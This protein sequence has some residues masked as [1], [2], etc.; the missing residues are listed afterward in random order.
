MNSLISISLFIVVLKLYARLN[1]S[2]IPPFFKCTRARGYCWNTTLRVC[3]YTRINCS[4]SWPFLF[5]FFQTDIIRFTLWLIEFHH[6]H[7]FGM[8]NDFV[9]KNETIAQHLTKMF[10]LYPK[11]LV[12]TLHCLI[13]IVPSTRLRQTLDHR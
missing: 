1:R 9:R 5:Y 13:L 6:L 11:T 7:D 10:N 8:E 4:K 3:S 2:L 12:G